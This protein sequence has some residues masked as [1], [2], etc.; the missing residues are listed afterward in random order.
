M[1]RRTDTSVFS[2][3]FEKLSWHRGSKQKQGARVVYNNVALEQTSEHD[4]PP[5]KFFKTNIIKVFY[6]IKPK[7]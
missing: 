3:C 7:C 6:I 4:I 1:E 5:Q 2:A